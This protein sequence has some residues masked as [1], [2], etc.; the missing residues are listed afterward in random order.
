MLQRIIEK[1]DGYGSPGR[2][3]KCKVKF[4]I[5]KRGAADVDRGF[6]ANPEPLLKEEEVTFLVGEEQVPA[7]LERCVKE[8]KKGGISEF[9]L[10]PDSNRELEPGTELHLHVNMMTYDAAPTAWSLAP[11]QLFEESAKRKAQGNEA[12]K[13]KNWA[14]AMGKYK[15]ALEFL[16]ST[17]KMSE[18]Q[19]ARAKTEKAVV[20]GNQTAVHLQEGDW[21]DVKDCCKKVLEIDPNNFKAY[22]RRARAELERDEWE[23]CQKTIEKCLESQPGEKETLRIKAELAKKQKDQKSKEGKIFAGMFGKLGDLGYPEKQEKKK[24]VKEEPKPKKDESD[25]D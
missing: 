11:E 17:G 13:V 8:M 25:S 16:D 9:L 3:D 20:L 23:N 14:R 24:K 2:E 15:H 18:E 12:Y 19:K 10:S 7:F 6:A 21:A 5:K 22:L 4:L 1:G